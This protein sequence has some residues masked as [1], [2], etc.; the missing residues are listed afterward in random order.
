MSLFRKKAVD[1]QGYRLKGGVSLLQP[2][3]IHILTFLFFIMIVLVGLF[4]VT[5]TYARKET[6]KGY[7][8]PD[9]GMIS[10]YSESTG[11]IRQLHVS[12]GDVVRKGEAL[13]TIAQVR[14]LAS[15]VELE[16]S[17]LKE[18]SYQL[19]L[20][21]KEAEKRERMFEIET[22]NL[23]QELS[24]LDIYVHNLMQQRETLR[25]RLVLKLKLFERTESIFVNQF[26]SPAD[27]QSQ[28]E[29]L[30]LV[31][32]AAE[33]AEADVV[34][35]ELR[36]KQ[37]Q[38]KLGDLPERRQLEV[39]DLERR[40]ASLLRQQKEIEGRFSHVIRSTSSGQV[41]AVRVSSGEF[42]VPG[43]SLLTILPEGAE[44][45][46]ELLL[47]SRS[48]GFVKPGNATR[49]R[50]DAFP[51]QR[52]GF[53]ESNVSQVDKAI[54]TPRDIRL[55]IAAKEPFYRVRVELPKQSVQAYGQSI[56]L[57]SGMQLEADII[58]ERRT[59]LQWLLD[60]IYSLKGRIG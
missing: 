5:A 57:R 9:K 6:V 15:G 38:I 53:V 59:L 27:Y 51:Y 10:V 7:L 17:L 56:P 43:K 47:P 46:A 55:P 54:L 49:L 18:I 26:I 24:S 8:R 1:A 42:L 36:R 20:I 52:F 13:V 39:M 33:Q 35:A 23:E 31:R 12:E 22:A 19:E 29:Q 2:D 50:F 34:S 40:R 32:Y 37:T 48:I 21:H 16:E 60:P 45:I 4:I 28:R 58:L 25:Q 11:S 3:Y 14:S 41:T 30:L 44:L